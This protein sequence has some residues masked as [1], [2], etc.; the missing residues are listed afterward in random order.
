MSNYMIP[1]PEP[2]TIASQQEGE[3]LNQ[4]K[5]GKLI[6]E[7][8]R[9]HGLLQKAML[10]LKLGWEIVCSYV[11]MTPEA[12]QGEIH[13]PALPD[14]VSGYMNDGSLNSYDMENT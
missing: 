3:K 6:A 1:L 2:A 9:K 7:C 13:I 8:R 14:Y 5:I 12:K 10:R 4:I 11:F